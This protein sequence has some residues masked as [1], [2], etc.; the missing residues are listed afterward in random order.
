MS[1]RTYFIE[2]VEYVM[3]QLSGSIVAL[4]TPYTEEGDIDYLSMEQLIEWH[5]AEG[6]DAIVLCGTTG[7]A[8]A[9]TQEEHLEIIRQGIYF[10]AG[11]IPIIAGTGSYNT[12]H[13]IFLT[14]QAQKMGAQASLVVL[15]YYNRPTPEGCFRHFQ[16]MSKVGLPLIVYHHPGRT[17]IK[18]TVS[19]LAKISE[20][21]EVVAIKEASADINFF[22]DLIQV[23]EKPL[24]SGDDTLAIPCI[25]SGGR[26]VISIVANVIPR[27]WKTLMTDLLAHR[28]EQ[29]KALFR[30]IY[31]LVQA[32]VLE[33]NPQ[34][35]K[36][37]LHLMGKSRSALRLPLL[38]PREE[39]QQKIRSALFS[40]YLMDIE[41]PMASLKTLKI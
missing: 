3:N 17:G 32:M 2:G 23:V 15:P 25:A 4:V 39:T 14:E 40:T 30:K 27:L 8:P 41:S 20:I 24:F 7:E 37:A 38:E 34:C 36:Y 31:P 13:S 21:P 6:T 29:G 19:A 5:I 12:V 10:A 18:L 33:T 22:I 11:R 26:G 9:L 1:G 16:E 35:V 28:L